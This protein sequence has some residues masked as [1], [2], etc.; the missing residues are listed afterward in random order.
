[1]A[2]VSG[3]STYVPPWGEVGRRV[4]GGDEDA[5]TMAVE[6]GRAALEAAG[7]GAVERVV[8]VSRDLPLLEGGNSAALLAG[9]GLPPDTDVVER[10]GGAPAALDA[11]LTARPRTLVTAADLDPA[12][13]GA[14]VVSSNGPVLRP[15]GRVTRSLPVQARSANGVVHRYDDP[16]LLRER[17]LLASLDRLREHDNGLEGRPTAIAGAPFAQVR[18]LCDGEPPKLP[19]LGASATVFALAAL[20]ER[21]EP[22]TLAAAE[23]AS[24]TAAV[25]D[26]SAGEPAHIHRLEPAARAVPA[27]HTTPGLDMP[28]SLAAYDRAFESKVG[29]KAARCESCGTLAL[30]RRYRCRG[31][32]TEGEWS[33]VPLPRRAVVYTTTTVHVPV[34]SLTTPYSLAVVQ[35]DG[36]DVRVLARTTAAEP[37]SVSIGDT[38]RMTLRRVAVRSGVPDYGYA[39]W[40]DDVPEG[41]EEEVR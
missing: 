32:G 38:G 31:C 18:A 11:I 5:V 8:L 36:T 41:H 19:V 40:P 30:P 37:G 17:G 35:L 39:F 27:A 6:A 7:T 21:K 13:A 26:T 15:V 20:A 4:P 33:L 3:I 24:L 23:Q 25:L 1:M 34:P 10:L 22:A 14:V 2:Y 16:R 28:V 9:L 12:G 29:W